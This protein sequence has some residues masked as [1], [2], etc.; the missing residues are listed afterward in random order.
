MELKCIARDSQFDADTSLTDRNNTI[1]QLFSA[2]PKVVNPKLIIPIAAEFDADYRKHEKIEPPMKDGK[3]KTQTWY[4]EVSE[5]TRTEIGAGVPV[6]SPLRAANY[7]R[8]D[9]GGA[10]LTSDVVKEISRIVVKHRAA[11]YY[12][13][14]GTTISSSA[15]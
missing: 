5:L 1:P 13:S 3:E 9:T 14:H 7:S 2:V 8:W 10:E 11:L 4:D 15:K 6:E 12:N